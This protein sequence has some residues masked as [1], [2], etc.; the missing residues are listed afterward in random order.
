MAGLNLRSKLRCALVRLSRVSEVR[1]QS[2]FQLPCT[3]LMVVQDNEAS[4][5]ERKASGRSQAAATG[6]SRCKTCKRCPLPPSPPLSALP[7][8]ALDLHV[9]F[10]LYIVFDAADEV[11]SG[12]HSMGDHPPE[13]AP[14][15]PGEL[16]RVLL[17]IVTRDLLFFL[18]VSLS[19]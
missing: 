2:A 7:R 6:R 15:S 8:G 1:Q 18:V 17:A 19:H 4:R 10:D 12:D 5:E 16:S 14:S 13:A 3:K 9:V 11:P